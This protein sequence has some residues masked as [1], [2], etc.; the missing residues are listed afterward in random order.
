MF[1]HIGNSNIVFNDEL[2]GIFKCATEEHNN[3]NYSIFDL[4]GQ[5]ILN[6]CSRNVN[7]RSYVVTRDKVYL[8]PIS[9]LT[10]LR[11]NKY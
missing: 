10:L 2:I 7:P 6:N 8:S 5:E 9:P 4:K 1:L 11:R 3:Y